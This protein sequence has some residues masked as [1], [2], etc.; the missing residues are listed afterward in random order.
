MQCVKWAVGDAR[1]ALAHGHFC[2]SGGGAG[3]DA[4]SDR[5]ALGA[6]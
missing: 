6:P 1:D 5:C 2:F 3:D 4:E